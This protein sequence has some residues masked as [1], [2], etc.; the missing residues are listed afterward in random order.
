MWIELI[1]TLVPVGGFLVKRLESKDKAEADL[2]RRTAM[3]NKGAELPKNRL[4]VTPE[5][6]AVLQKEKDNKDA[7]R[8]LNYIAR[9][10]NA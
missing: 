2:L 9:I 7:I 8:K 3:P 10:I 6:I 4:E 1:K 5:L